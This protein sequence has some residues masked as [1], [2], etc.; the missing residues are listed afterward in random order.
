MTYELRPD[1]RTVI[2][3]P[4][5]EVVE[6]EAE[7]LGYQKTSTGW[8]KKKEVEEPRR[9]A[10]TKKKKKGWESWTPEMRKKL[11]GKLERKYGSIEEA[12]KRGHIIP[13]WVREEYKSKSA[14]K[15]VESDAGLTD[16]EL[17]RAEAYRTRGRELERRI[18]RDEF[19]EPS[20]TVTIS[21]DEIRRGK[22]YFKTGEIETGFGTTLIT[23]EREEIQPVISPD[24]EIRE[25]IGERYEPKP[26]GYFEKQLLELRQKGGKAA[27]ETMVRE[28]KGDWFTQLGERAKRYLIGVGVGATSTFLGLGYLG[29]K[30]IGGQPFEAGKELVTGTA[31]WFSKAP[32]RLFSGEAYTTG[33]FVGEAGAGYVIG[34]VGVRGVKAGARGASTL[35]KG[36]KEIIVEQVGPHTPPTLIRDIAVAQRTVNEVV[37]GGKSLGKTIVE[38]TKSLSKMGKRT[39]GKFGETVTVG[40]AKDIAKLELLMG[41]STEVARFGKELGKDVKKLYYDIPKELSSEV[42]RGVKKYYYDIPAKYTSR[43]ISK[44]TESAKK[45]LRD[46]AIN[47]RAID[48]AI[49]RQIKHLGWR[50]SEP[51]YQRGWMRPKSTPKKGITISDTLKD[52]VYSL[53]EEKIPITRELPEAVFIERPSEVIG[54]SERVWL[55]EQYKQSK[56]LVEKVEI[57]KLPEELQK[58]GREVYGGFIEEKPIKVKKTKIIDLTAIEELPLREAVEEPRLTTKWEQIERAR[59]ERIERWFRRSQEREVEQMQKTGQATILRQ[60]TKEEQI[61]RQIEKSG[62]RQIIL[63]IYLMGAQQQQL[64]QQKS[65]QKTTQNLRRRYV[66]SLYQPSRELSRE[67]SLQEGL[68]SS[69]A[70]SITT[71]VAENLVFKPKLA[72]IEDFVSQIPE[73]IQK[74]ALMELEVGKLIAVEDFFEP[75]FVAKKEKEKR[76]VAKK[77]KRGYAWIRENPFLELEQIVGA[78]SRIADEMYGS[79]MKR[80]KS[81]SKSKTKSKPKTSKTKKKGRKR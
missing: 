3:G 73:H 22:E 53:R 40:V 33:Q 35:A 68:I 55:W 27:V 45:V 54:A 78:F 39:Y 36:T 58:H 28:A 13:K 46:A 34:E 61:V 15:V 29:E 52:Y 81:K 16:I 11:I 30:A 60:I 19:Y 50:I 41:R 66:T 77:K 71:A 65:L 25:N 32:F 17:R 48:V 10:P 47:L 37:S 57:E 31:E 79:P 7:R 72:Q 23:K 74:Q 1:E 4:S 67:M 44:A 24:R 64:V 18:V 62:F 56:K 12:E 80:S 51:F 63:P 42:E 6:K 49:D 70:T 14:K 2:V 8:V 38:E 43:G 9:E 26:E 69:T 5:E 59:F 20:K 76:K 75:T 21:G